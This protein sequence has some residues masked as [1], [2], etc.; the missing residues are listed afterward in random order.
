M[1]IQVVFHTLFFKLKAIDKE[2]RLFA[3]LIINGSELKIHYDKETMASTRKRASRHYWMLESR[4]HP[5]VSPLFTSCSFVSL[6]SSAQFQRELNA[7][8]F[9]SEKYTDQRK[10]G[11]NP[12]RTNK[13]VK[14]HCL[15][16]CVLHCGRHAI[17]LPFSMDF[18]FS[19]QFIYSV[20]RFRS[21][22]SILFVWL[23]APMGICLYLWPVDCVT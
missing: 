8:S 14:K 19:L 20:N 5:F 12:P 21:I 9:V 17:Q 11:E 23:L 16:P 6:I 13:T 3:H 7:L 1:F 15:R 18:C 10:K 22:L 4:A 2:I